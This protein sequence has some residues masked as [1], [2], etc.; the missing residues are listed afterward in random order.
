M[1]NRAQA[2]GDEAGEEIVMGSVVYLGRDSFRMETVVE[3][4][5]ETDDGAPREVTG[6]VTSPYRTRTRG[7]ANDAAGLDDARLDD[8]R[9]DDDATEIIARARAGQWRADEPSATDPLFGSQPDMPVLLSAP[10]GRLFGRRRRVS[11]SRGALVSTGMLLFACGLASS[12]V[13]RRATSF[14][15]T[16]VA[17]QARAMPVT[18][19][20]V[21][22]LPAEPA[23]PT[24][25]AVITPAMIQ[26]PE[27]ILVRIHKRTTAVS[28]ST[29][30]GSSK[31]ARAAVAR[32][33]DP[34]AD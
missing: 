24:T 12:A 19:E 31:V 6:I 27:P 3:P 7:P 23:P 32:W 10:T 8:A 11:L 25:T 5:D 16:T 29:A 26:L 18:I 17:V 21:A 1:I 14:R 28:S 15:A 9:L 20:T 2:M 4:L 30:G 13:A 22:V 33:V 34:F